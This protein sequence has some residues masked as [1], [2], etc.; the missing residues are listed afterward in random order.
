MTPELLNQIEGMFTY[1]LGKAKGCHGAA[2]ESY[3]TRINTIFLTNGQ[4]LID[5]SR[6]ALA[7]QSKPD[8]ETTCKRR[9]KSVKP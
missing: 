2:R 4:S 3:L 6:Q 1:F 8:Y 5:L 7:M 9:L